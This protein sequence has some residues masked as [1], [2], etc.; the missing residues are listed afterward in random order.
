MEKSGILFPKARASSASDV[1]TV[2]AMVPEAKIV[3]NVCWM[4]SRRL[5]CGDCGENAVEELMNS[6]GMRV[7]NLK[8][9]MTNGCGSDIDSDSGVGSLDTDTAGDTTK[10]HQDILND[11][12]IV[13]KNE[14]DMVQ[15]SFK[16]SLSLPLC[17]ILSPLLLTLL[18]NIKF[19]KDSGSQAQCTT[20][21][22][23]T[24]EARTRKDHQLHRYSA[25]PG[26]QFH[27]ESIVLTAAY[28]ILSERINYNIIHKVLQDGL[29][30][31]TYYRNPSNSFWK[32]KVQASS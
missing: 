23:H 31:W 6:N 18:I 16:R 22:T 27:I 7:V 1:R 28:R 2:A 21:H 11:N 26:S 12:S 32:C 4:A 10:N 15:R 30:L 9:V 17:F 14:E 3:A 24:Q 20:V 13:K 29:G 8:S 25:K 5:I 19:M